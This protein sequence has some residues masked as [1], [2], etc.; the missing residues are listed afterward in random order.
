MGA[1]S[2]S[3]KIWLWVVA[4]RRFLTVSTI[5]VQAPT[6]DVKLTAKGYR[7]DLHV[8]SLMV[9]QVQPDGGENWIVLESEPTRSLVVPKLPQSLLLAVCKFCAASKEHCKQ[10]YRRVCVK[11]CCWAPETHQNDHSN[12]HDLELRADLLSILYTRNKHGGRLH[13]NVHD[14]DSLHKK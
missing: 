8:T 7:I 1:R 9:H 4:W 3:I 13:S 14:L 10:G 5:S 2:S 6:P 12:V 11:L